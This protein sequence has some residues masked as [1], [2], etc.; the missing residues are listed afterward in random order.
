MVRCV[1][2]WYEGSSSLFSLMCRRDRD[3]TERIDGGLAAHNLQIEI[4]N[5]SDFAG[6]AQL[7]VARQ[8]TGIE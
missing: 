3:E 5:T 6:T 7:T 4:V 8:R 2:A 1:L